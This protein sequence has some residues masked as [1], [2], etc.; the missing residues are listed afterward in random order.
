MRVDVRGGRAAERAALA[1]LADAPASPDGAPP[2]L[3]RAP[4]ALPRR[5]VRGTVYAPLKSL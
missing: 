2:S 1:L 5:W 3:V 4:P